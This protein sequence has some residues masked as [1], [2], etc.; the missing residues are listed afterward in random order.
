MRGDRDRGGSSRGSRLVSEV[1][2]AEVKLI[3]DE[4]VLFLHL[5]PSRCSLGIYPCFSLL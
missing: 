2:L 3:E 5:D 1:E 4:S